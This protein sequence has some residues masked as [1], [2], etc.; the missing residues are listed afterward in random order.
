[1]KSIPVPTI[2]RLSI[3][4]TLLCRLEISREEPLS[5]AKIGEMMGISSHTVRKDISYLD[6]EGT[7]AGYDSEALKNALHK[8]LGLSKNRKA[9]I[10]GLGR[11]GCAILSF[12]KY[13]GGNIKIVAGFDSSINVLETIETD[14][15]VYPAYD[16]PRIVKENQIEIAVVA[17]PPE[18]VQ[19][20]ANRLLDGGIKGIIN[21]APVVIKTNDESIVVKNFHIMEEL[22]ALAI[23]IDQKEKERM[24]S[25]GKDI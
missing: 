7:E 12:G 1:M 24:N 4:Y 22:R 11:L 9:C 19:L 16:I 17:V 18:Q 23:M 5:S 10:I 2:E 13:M 21:F 3:L 20:T 8:I 14:V 15:P 25:N 6:I